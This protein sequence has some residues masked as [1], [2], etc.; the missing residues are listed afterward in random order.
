MKYEK[1]IE[2]RMLAEETK[3]NLKNLKQNLDKS[4]ETLREIIKSLKQEII[5]IAKTKPE[6]LKYNPEVFENITKNQKEMEKFVSKNDIKIIDEKYFNVPEINQI[7][8]SLNE[9]YDP[10]I[11]ESYFLKAWNE[12]QLRYGIHR[13]LV[14]EFET[15][16]ED[17]IDQM[18]DVNEIHIGERAKK[19]IKDYIKIVK[20]DHFREYSTTYARSQDNYRIDV[21]LVISRKPIFLG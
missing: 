14:D 3:S 17:D 15:I 5:E 19:H 1:D 11:M 18:I 7:I 10:S 20:T 9:N 4:R 8:V 16:Y 2:K 13:S 6:I 21:G 12:D